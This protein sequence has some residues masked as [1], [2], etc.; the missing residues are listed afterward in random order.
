MAF[1]AGAEK[2]ITK[3]ISI[4]HFICDIFMVTAFEDRIGY[5]V[6]CTMVN[7]T[8]AKVFKYR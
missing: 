5:T 1:R 2:I 3:K 7:F 8:V 6:K 4:Q